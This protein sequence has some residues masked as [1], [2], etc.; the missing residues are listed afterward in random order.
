MIIENEIKDESPE[1]EN[2]RSANPE[3]LHSEKA[4]EEE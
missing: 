3:S 2:E 4:Q 1:D